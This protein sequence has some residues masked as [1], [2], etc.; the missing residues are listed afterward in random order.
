[1]AN[2]SFVLLYVDNPP[3]SVK[4]YNE[5]FDLADID[6]TDASSP[7]FGMV[8]LTAGVKLGLWKRDGVAPVATAPTGGSEIAYT[9]ADK[10]EV[11]ELHAAWKRRGLTIAQAPT[12]MDFGFTFTALDPD[13]N[14]IRVFAPAAN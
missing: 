9:A 6:C 8:P 7:T 1:M 14:R 2:F 3:A 11:T 13:G 10:A 5:L 12:E 4:F